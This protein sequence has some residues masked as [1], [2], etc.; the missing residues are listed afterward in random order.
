[1]SSWLRR[2]GSGMHVSVV[3]FGRAGVV[4]GAVACMSRGLVQ[5]CGATRDK[6]DQHTRRVCGVARDDAGGGTWVYIS[7]AKA[8]PTLGAPSCSTTSKRLPADSLR[9]RSRQPWLVMSS[10]MVSAPRTGLIGTRSTPMMRA[11][12]GMCFAHTCSERHIK[13]HQGES[14]PRWAGRGGQGHGVALV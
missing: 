5:E 1:M 13:A 9:R 8:P 2:R 6:R 10:V 7:V 12:I 3:A 11:D 4:H 14:R